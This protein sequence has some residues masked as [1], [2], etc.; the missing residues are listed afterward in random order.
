MPDSKMGCASEGS[1]KPQP[2]ALLR[3]SNHL[4]LNRSGRSRQKPPFGG[5]LFAFLLRFPVGVAAA[6]LPLVNRNKGG[7]QGCGGGFGEQSKGTSSC[8]MRPGPVHWIQL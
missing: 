8:P 5:G 7:V 4:Q 6:A 3:F 1:R 2:A